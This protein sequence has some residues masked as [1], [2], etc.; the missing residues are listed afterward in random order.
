MVLVSAIHQHESVIG[1]HLSL[2]PPSRLPPHPTPLGWLRESEWGREPAG[3][4]AGAA[5][6]HCGAE[7]SWSIFPQTVAEGAERGAAPLATV[8]PLSGAPVLCALAAWPTGEKAPARLS[9]G[10]KPRVR[11]PCSPPQGFLSLI[12]WFNCYILWITAQI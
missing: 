9:L 4:R 2:E 11:K 7:S 8:C 12:H 10:Q 5:R 1:I 6:E 3:I